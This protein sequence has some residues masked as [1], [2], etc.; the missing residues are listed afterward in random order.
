[1]YTEE[2]VVF[3]NDDNKLAGTLTL[4]DKKDK[5]PA[6]I[7]LPGSGPVNRDE[8]Y[9]GFKPFK[10]IADH[11]TKQGIAT[12]RWDARGVGGST[13]NVYASTFPDFAKDVMAAINYLKDRREINTSQ[14]GLCGHSQGGFIAPICAS[15]SDD[16]SFIILIS[17]GGHSGK[18]LFL[19]QNEL[20]MK[21]DGGKEDEINEI[22]KSQKILISL[23]LDGANETRIESIL[24]D[25]TKRSI[26]IKK[27]DN[28]V[29]GDL[30]KMI[31][32]Q[33]ACQLM[34]FNNPW[35]RYFLDYDPKPILK[36]V[37]C[38]V[39]M[40]FGE[41]DLQV[42][43]KLNKDAMI[44]ALKKGGNK[45]CTIKIFPSANHLF[46]FAKTG[47]PAEYGNLDKKFVPGFLKFMSDW[48]LK[49]VDIVT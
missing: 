46:Q 5:H 17:G 8:E 15:E 3:N 34:S 33:V 19:A 4:P 25:I 30:D 16:V 18:K 14:I 44:E 35:F 37:N 47:S 1:M 11:F 7:M 24:T 12:L 26:N 42:P 23:I 45:K 20:I 48:I 10:V 28:I 27:G 22:L 43:T 31:K 29:T 6:I 39:L 2:E 21:A 13:G 32:D 38:P 40:L 9:L 49:R 36:K 41:L